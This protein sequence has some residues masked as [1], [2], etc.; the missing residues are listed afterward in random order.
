[1]DRRTINSVNDTKPP[2]Y[3]IQD[4]HGELIEGSFYE[5]ELQK[6]NQEIFRIE[7]VLK[8]RQRKGKDGGGDIKE[9]YVNWIGHN[10]DFNSSVPVSELHKL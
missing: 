6:S 9:A 5:Q 8:K 7:K 3:T 10:S 1:M 4:L 2:T